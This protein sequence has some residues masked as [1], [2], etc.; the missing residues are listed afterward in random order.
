MGGGKGYNGKGERMTIPTVGGTV[1]TVGG[2]T[3]RRFYDA[4]TPEQWGGKAAGLTRLIDTCLVKVPWFTGLPIGAEKSGSASQWAQRLMTDINCLHSSLR[5]DIELNGLAV[6]SGARHSMPG[7]METLLRVPPTLSNLTEAI[8][9]VWQSFHSPQA[10]AYRQQEFGPEPEPGEEG[11]GVVIQQ[12]ILPPPNSRQFSGVAMTADLHDPL[13]AKTFSPLIQFVEGTGDSLVRGEVT[14]ST[15]P[16]DPS[17]LTPW[18]ADVYNQ[19]QKLHAIL[20]ASDLEWTVTVTTPESQWEGETV[21][22]W[23]LQHRKIEYPPIELVKPNGMEGELGEV[24]AIGEPIGA[25]VGV[26]AT[27]GKSLLWMNQFLPEH[28]KKMLE[29][30][31]LVSREGGV[32]SHAAIVGRKLG[33]P[34]ISGIEWKELKKWA[35]KRVWVDGELGVVAEIVREDE[36]IELPEEEE[37]RRKRKVHRLPESAMLL[38]M[39]ERGEKVLPLSWMV[40][41]FYEAH[42][43]GGRKEEKVARKIAEVLAGYLA[44][45]SLG[46]FRHWKRYHNPRKVRLAELA[47]LEEEMVERFRTD[48]I[49]RDEIQTH[50]KLGL[51]RDEWKEVMSIMIKGFGS[52][53]RG[54]YG[55]KKWK[56]IVSTVWDWMT[57]ELSSALFVDSVFNICHNGSRAFDKMSKVIRDDG[58]V[59]NKLLD[60]KRSGGLGELRA[61]WDEWVKD[62]EGEWEK[63]C[64]YDSVWEWMEAE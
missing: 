28:Y 17:K 9:K 40:R 49:G 43:V 44:V 25:K 53:W 15:F 39:R 57:D 1:P 50:A 45:A 5:K 22:V 18:Q 6:R 48:M 36:E 64:E 52:G 20:G 59:V 55:G 31:A 26:T 19:A 2:T 35:G 27:V 23:W 51:N 33:K 38:E 60:A 30:K 42:S 10:V 46:E 62:E 3:L 8:E 34:A 21:V 7:M 56:N 14:P 16:S 63:Y 4:V 11:T 54:G 47:G 41:E 12:M 13:K 58:V 29:A 61:A 32:L 24:I 37:K